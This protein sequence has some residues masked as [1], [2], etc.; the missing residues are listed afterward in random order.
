MVLGCKLLHTGACSK[1]TPAAVSLIRVSRPRHLQAEELDV[2][3]R[4]IVE[5]IPDRRY[6]TMGSNAGA[7]SGEFHMYRAVSQPC[8]AGGLVCLKL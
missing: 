3:L 1:A 8:Q 7:G 4:Y 5:D 6:H 2:K